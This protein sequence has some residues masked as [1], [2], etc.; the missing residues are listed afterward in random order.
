MRYF[1]IF[2]IQ[3]QNV[4]QERGRS[5]VWFLM[6]AV[7]PLIVI[8]FWKGAANNKQL[9][10][11]WDFAS[12]ASYYF[13]L[14]VAFSLIVSHVEENVSRQHIQEG[15]LV[16]YLVKPISYLGIKFLEEMPY[17]ILQSFYGSILCLVFFVFF[18]KQLFVI[19]NDPLI[20][21][22]SCIIIV[23][24][25]AIS[26]ITRM[27]MGISA[28]WF[29]DSRGMYEALYATEFA[30]GGTLIPLILLPP[31]LMH[32]AYI[33]PFAYIIYFPIAAF[34]GKL[35]LINEVGVIGMQTLWI[36]LFGFIYRIL[37]SAGVKKFSGVGQ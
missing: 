14:T 21:F 9:A 28:F 34:Q 32:I 23:L 17:R 1:Q 27:L 11:G 2:L 12:L 16:M 33:L 22:F 36:I 37:W 15:N 18:G 30:L 3:C 13:F 25:I 6:A 5:F 7:N 4:L 26:F 19:S 35:N 20:L 8:L 31:T 24:G 29:T 10:P